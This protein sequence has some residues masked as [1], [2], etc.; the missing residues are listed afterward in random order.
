MTITYESVLV[1]LYLLFFFEYQVNFLQNYFLAQVLHGVL[2]E[3]E[4]FEKILIIHGIT[5]KKKGEYK[6]SPIPLSE[7]E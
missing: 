7:A 3:R 2:Q 6:Q 4:D 1:I 5:P